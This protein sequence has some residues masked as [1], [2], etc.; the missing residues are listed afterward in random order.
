MVEGFL[1]GIIV[2]SSLTAACFFLKFWR[3]THD[4]LFLAFAVAFLIEG[5]NRIGVLF[6]AHPNEGRP[7]MYL[8]RLF[9]FLLIAAA[10]VR[11]NRER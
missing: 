11:K 1:L 6:L 4:V 10:I 8:V 7:E 2:A 3:R 9:A 5:L